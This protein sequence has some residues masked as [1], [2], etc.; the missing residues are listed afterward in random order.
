MNQK[1]YSTVDLARLLGV[2][3]HRLSYALRVGKVPE[4]NLKVAGKR[5]FTQEEA[6]RISEYF[7]VDIKNNET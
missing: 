6:R 5:L 2:A 7:G 4:P 3:E 1:L